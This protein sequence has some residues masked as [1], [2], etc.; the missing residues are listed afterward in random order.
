MMPDP[1][2]V[3]LDHVPVPVPDLP[4][5]PRFP[6]VYSW[7]LAPSTADDPAAAGLV[8]PVDPSPLYRSESGALLLYVG[9]ARRNLH[10]RIR[11]QHLQRTRSSALRRTLLA[12]LWPLSPRWA[13]G[14]ALDIRGR[15]DPG[16]QAEDCLSAWMSEHLLVGWIQ[17]DDVAEVDALEAAW[18]A[19]YAPPLN[20]DGTAHR[21]KLVSRKQ[22]FVQEIR[23]RSALGG[24]SD[25]P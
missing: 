9:R 1:E 19:C 23:R 2:V 13:E 15:V 14:A 22:D 12:S 16:K 17:L 11:R 24:H 5:L 10:Q 20:T 4:D 6:G 8:L 25:H 18:I 21:P 3:P 7:W